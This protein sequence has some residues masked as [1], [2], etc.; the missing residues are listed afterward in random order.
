MTVHNVSIFSSLHLDLWLHEHVPEDTGQCM[1]SERAFGVEKSMMRV[2]KNDV[3]RGNVS[4]P[5]F[6][7]AAD[8]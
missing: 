6:N 2:F 5:L 8:K 1:L 4:I 7:S 3:K